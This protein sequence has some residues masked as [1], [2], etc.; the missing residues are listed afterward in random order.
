[1]GRDLSAKLRREY[2]KGSC[3]FHEGESCKGSFVVL[4]GTVVLST[5]YKTNRDLPVAVLKRGAVIGLP[6]T[7]GGHRCQTTA[8]ALTNV[9]VH[10]IPSRDVLSMMKDDP[11]T[12]L[13]V[14]TML[15]SDLGHLYGR[16]RRIATA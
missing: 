13:R 8:V 10:F 5:G 7:V 14:V 4:R 1:V 3:L 16:I 6:E 11:E 15:I 12:S 2:K 9:T